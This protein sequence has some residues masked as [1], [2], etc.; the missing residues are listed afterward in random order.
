MDPEVCAT[1]QARELAGQPLAAFLRGVQ[2]K[3][4]GG[5]SGFER[6]SSVPGVIWCKCDFTGPYPNAIVFM[7]R[8]LFSQMSKK[9]QGPPQWKC[10]RC[11]L[12][13]C[14][15]AGLR[16]Y[17]HPKSAWGRARPELCK[18]GRTTSDGFRGGGW[19]VAVVRSS[20]VALG[21]GALERFGAAPRRGGTSVLVVGRQQSSDLRGDLAPVH[22]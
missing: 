21:L 4:W 2:A 7:T 10:R 19:T 14:K 18:V 6:T 17:P 20:G 15:Q 8:F 13:S 22:G 5:S 12:A 9:K 16:S 11:P 3:I 1:F